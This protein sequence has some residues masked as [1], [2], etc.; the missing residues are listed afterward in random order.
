MTS[1]APERVRA[2]ALVGARAEGDSP[3]RRAGRADTIALIE[4]GGAEAL[5]ENQRPKLMLED[6]PEQAVA[7]E[8]VLARGKDELIEAVRALRDRA[9]N[10]ETFASFE[11]SSLVAVGEGDAFFPLEEAEALAAR[12]RHGRFRVFAGA[13]HLPSLEQPDEF[14]AALANF[15]ADV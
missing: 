13:K 12:A 1:R 10:S 4:S 7:R 15:L 9:D 6:A 14:N 3:E 5:W 11:G 8:L 2:L